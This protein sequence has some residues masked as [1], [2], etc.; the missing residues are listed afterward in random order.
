MDSWRDFV[1]FASYSTCSVQYFPTQWGTVKMSI[2]LNRGK[3]VIL[4]CTVDHSLCL[5]TA[6]QGIILTCECDDIHNLPVCGHMQVMIKACTAGLRFKCVLR[7]RVT[8]VFYLH[9][10]TRVFRLR[11]RRVLRLRVIRVFYLGLDV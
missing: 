7:L 10:F 11:F 2:S 1:N 5:C 6:T 3:R 4:L 9:R 8:R